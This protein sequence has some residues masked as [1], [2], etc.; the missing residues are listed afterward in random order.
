MDTLEK[1]FQIAEGF[2]RPTHFHQGL[3]R[4]NAL[5]DFFV[6]ELLAAFQLSFAELHRLDKTGLFLEV[7]SK[8]FLG[9]LIGSA[10]LRLGHLSKLR[11]LVFCE[12]N[13]HKP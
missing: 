8:N 13:F 11:D 12:R 5:T 2:G 1:A 9:K 3:P 10:P 7:S 6:T 4:R